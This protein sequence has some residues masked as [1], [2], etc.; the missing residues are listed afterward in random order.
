MTSRL[1]GLAAS[2]SNN[3]INMDPAKLHKHKHTYLKP[4]NGVVDS[5]TIPA[6]SPRLPSDDEVMGDLG[7]DV[8]PSNIGNLE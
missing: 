6:P 2:V 3:A 5:L 4:S 8:E 1:H 7:E